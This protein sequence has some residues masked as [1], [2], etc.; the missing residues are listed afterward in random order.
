MTFTKDNPFALAAIE[1]ARARRLRAV[2]AWATVAFLAGALLSY[3]A[4]APRLHHTTTP[5]TAYQ[6]IIAYTAD[7]WHKAYMDPNGDFHD[8]ETGN[9]I[10]VRLWYIPPTP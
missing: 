9:L 7:G 8:G 2:K 10:S 1:V 6:D 5:P 4:F 3:L